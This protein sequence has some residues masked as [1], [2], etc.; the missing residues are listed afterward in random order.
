MTNIAVSEESH[1]GQTEGANRMPFV[2]QV[3][4]DS[5]SGNM[6]SVHGHSPAEHE[7]IPCNPVRQAYWQLLHMQSTHYCIQ[8]VGNVQ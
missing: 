6:G 2:A 5:P 3:A 1:P 7:I 4:Q 8:G